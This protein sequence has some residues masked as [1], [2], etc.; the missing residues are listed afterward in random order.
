[1]SGSRK[2]KRCFITGGGRGIGRG[3]VEALAASGYDVTF[4][5]RSSTDAAESLRSELEKRFPSQNFSVLRADL[6]SSEDVDALAQE[7]SG[8]TD[9]YGFVHNAGGSYDALAAMIDRPRAEQIMQVNFWSMV[10]LVKAALRPM[11][12]AR[13]GRIVGVGSITA[14]RGTQG[15][16]AY[17]ATKGAM[18]SYMK[19]LCV[20]VARKGITANLVAP[21]YVD[22]DMLAPYAGQRENAEKQ[23]PCGRFAAPNEIA[24]L[25]CYLLA[26]EAAYVTGAEISIDGGL[27][28]SIA[29]KNQ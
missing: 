26:P 5:Y 29:M 1:M 18:A 13:A 28:A 23:I 15:N 10:V 11:M 9:L 25:V 7:L 4:S 22:T 3:I 16:G 21:G 19:S 12:R 2:K 20:E 17:A 6:A 8:W 24:S 14:R 27:S